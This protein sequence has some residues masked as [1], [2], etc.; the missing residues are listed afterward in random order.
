MTGFSLN[1]EHES[2]C[3]LH[4]NMEMCLLPIA[5]GSG[6]ILFV[7]SAKFFTLTVVYFILVLFD[8][9]LPICYFNPFLLFIILVY[10]ALVFKCDIAVCL[11]IGNVQ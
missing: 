5:G 4:K 3:K 1:Y 10:I 6:L 11:Q 9:F 8:E 7:T 2:G